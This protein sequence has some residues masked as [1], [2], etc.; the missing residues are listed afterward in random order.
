[1]FFISRGHYPLSD[2]HWLILHC[3]IYFV[4]VLVILRQQVNLVLIAYYILFSSRGP[5]IAF[6]ALIF[7]LI[8]RT[9]EKNVGGKQGIS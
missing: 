4:H 7:L 1:M 9:N 5:K 3:Y 8:W 6:E 2:V